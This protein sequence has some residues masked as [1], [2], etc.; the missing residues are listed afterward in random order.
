MAIHN[1]LKDYVLTFDTETAVLGDHVCEIGF[2][3]FHNGIMIREWGT[4][5]KPIVPIDPEASKVHQI[6]DKDVE[7]CPTFR[8]I[9]PWVY[10]VLNSYNIHCAYNY[11]YDRGVLENEF[12]RINMKFPIKPMIDPLVLFKRWFKFNKGK[13]LKDAAEKLG[14]SL[15]GAHRAMNDATATGNILFRLAATRNDFPKSIDSFLKKQYQLIEHQYE[16]F[17]EYRKKVNKDPPDP[18]RLQY[19]VIG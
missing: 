4:F 14:I 16:D 6:Y 13:K 15:I 12:N 7:S 5:V 1:Y 18:P 17:V 10:G 11:E 2:S 3:L 9:A 8:E 19:Y